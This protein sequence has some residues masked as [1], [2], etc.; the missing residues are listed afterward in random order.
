MKHEAAK[1]KQ[2]HRPNSQQPQHGMVVF[3]ECY[4]IQQSDAVVYSQ[5]NVQNVELICVVNAT[6]T[7]MYI[8][9]TKL[10]VIANSCL[11]LSTYLEVHTHL[12]HSFHEAIV[13]RYLL[14]PHYH[15]CDAST[16]S[17]C[18]KHKKGSILQAFNE[19]YSHRLQNY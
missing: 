18:L 13:S 15:C 6:P 3:V 12:L 5:W 16:L 1:Q 11:K 4:T 17:S 2:M 7:P 10:I 9:A 14:L 19:R 8:L